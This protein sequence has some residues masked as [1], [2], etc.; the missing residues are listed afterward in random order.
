MPR[1]ADPDQAAGPRR[2]PRRPRS[3]AGS[4]A[5]GRPTA[6][7]SPTPGRT[8]PGQ[9]HRRQGAPSRTRP[10][11]PPA[12]C[13]LGPTPSGRHRVQAA[14]TRASSAHR[15]ES[16]ALLWLPG[17]GVGEAQGAPQ[18]R[19]PGLLH[20]TTVRRAHAVV[21]WSE[22]FPLVRPS[23]RP[24]PMHLGEMGA[25][26]HGST[27]THLDAG[28]LAGTREDGDLHGWTRVDVLPPDGMQEIHAPLRGAPVGTKPG[29]AALL[30][31]WGPWAVCVVWMADQ[32]PRA[33]WGGQAW[34]GVPLVVTGSSW[35]VRG[36]MQVWCW[37]P[38]P[39]TPRCCCVRACQ[40]PVLIWAPAGGSPFPV[41]SE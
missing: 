7:S 5:A 36:R 32:L 15:S 22:G 31:G 8:Q 9:G 26:Q 2:W 35:P 10:W 14:G 20:R 39:G 37:G 25:V 34:A 18:R 24:R 1:R 27:A 40:S 11:R 21:A 38:M 19:F 28:G 41:V 6:T 33:G 23:S 16:R 17:L 29:P 3:S 4:L 12:S 30:A 13:S